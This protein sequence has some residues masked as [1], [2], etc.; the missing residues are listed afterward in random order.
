[1]I[2]ASFLFADSEMGD[3]TRHTDQFFDEAHDYNVSSGVLP[4][5]ETIPLDYSVPEAALYTWLALIGL[6][7]V[8]YGYRVF[9]T[10]M[11]LTGYIFATLIVYKVSG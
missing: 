11:A 7:F 3:Y 8:L 2:E 1:M 4:D 9:K 5:C 6:I 10:T